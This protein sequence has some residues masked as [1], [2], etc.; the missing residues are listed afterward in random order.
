MSSFLSATRVHSYSG[1]V[2]KITYIAAGSGGEG[3]CTTS[4]F[5]VRKEA[6]KPFVLDHYHSMRKIRWRYLL[7][8]KYLGRCLRISKFQ[9]TYD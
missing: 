1:V 5:G 7:N 9:E 6:A 4:S 3:D 8:D 2:V